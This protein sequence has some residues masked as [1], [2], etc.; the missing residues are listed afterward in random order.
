MRAGFEAA[1]QVQRDEIA[2]AGR[3]LRAFSLRREAA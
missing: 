2:A 3:G 1:R